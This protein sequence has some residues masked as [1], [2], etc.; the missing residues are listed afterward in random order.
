MSTHPAPDPLRL[1]SHEP[2]EPPTP[3]HGPGA[4]DALTSPTG[5]EH[6]SGPPPHRWG[7]SAVT[8]VW[9]V[10]LL[11]IA[12]LGAGYGLLGLTADPILLG[13]LVV[14]G[15]GLFLILVAAFGARR[16]SAAR[17]PPSTTD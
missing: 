13:A 11:A 15:C 3:E 2:A 1:H 16:R 9:G 6:G 7:P 14:A 8:I 5:P 10:L 17:Q 4:Q 12:A